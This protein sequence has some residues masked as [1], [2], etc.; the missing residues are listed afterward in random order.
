[1]NHHFQRDVVSSFVENALE[2]SLEGGISCGRVWPAPTQMCSIS[3]NPVRVAATGS[4][5][6]SGADFPVAGSAVLLS[7]RQE[8]WKN[9]KRFLM[10]FVWARSDSNFCEAN[11]AA[12]PHFCHDRGGLVI[13]TVLQFFKTRIAQIAMLMVPSKSSGNVL[14]VYYDSSAR[15]EF[16]QH[17]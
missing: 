5:A 4:A 17:L 12:L 2:E 6:C 11:S 10:F 15:R 1:L 7:V 14:Q 13:N 8:F 9:R 3:T 16:R